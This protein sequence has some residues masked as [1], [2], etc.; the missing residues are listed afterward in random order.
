MHMNR[1]TFLAKA[2]QKKSRSRKSI[3]PADLKQIEVVNK[4]ANKVLPQVARTTAGLEPYTGTWGFDQASHLLR[5]TMFGI[6]KSDVQSMLSFSMNQV[7][8][9]LLA[10]IP[11]PL[12]PV[13]TNTLDIDVPIG[14]TWVNSPKTDSNGY[15]PNSSRI[16]SMKS[17][18]IGLMLNQGISLREKMTLFWHN[19][20]VSE[21]NIVSDARF[22]YKQNNLFRQYAF[23]NF[24]NLTKAVTIDGAMLR[25]L[26]GNTNTRTN[27][28]E[29]YARE[30]Q[31]LFTIGK[32]PEI[33]PGNY[34]NYTEA[35]VQAAAKI[36]T[37]WRDDGTAI[38]SYFTSSL[39]DTSNKQFSADYGNTI[40]AGQ[41]GT[42]GANEIDDFLTMI[43]A[44][45]ETAKFICRKLYRYFVYYV[46]D[47]TTEAN[48]IVP[49]ANILRSN[50]YEIKPVLDTLFKSAHF[51]DPVN[52]GCIIKN[53]IEDCVG[54]CRQFS[55]PFPD[56]TNVATQYANWNYIRTQAANM[57]MDIGDPPNVAGWPAYY[58]IP[59]YYE[60]WIN[61]DTLPR[62]NQLSDTLINSGHTT[63]G[64]KLI[65]DPIAFVNQVSN[66]ADPNIIIAEF[67]Q[68]L[69]PIAITANQTAFL[70]ETLIPGLPDY[71]WAIEWNSYLLDPTN[72]TKLT[73]VKTKLQA[74]IGFMMDMAE[75]QLQ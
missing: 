61:S 25:Y 53:P 55:I 9:Q 50:N 16:Q 73:A 66:P 28:N 63:S 29:N 58:Q 75:Y 52:I 8:A 41:I 13:N 49:L 1:R 30:L 47:T 67:V 40:I 37:G 18:W 68:I 35:D 27:P 2:S 54:L 39:H 4:F 6:K 42:A 31:E 23:G 11:L 22:S 62:R 21:T 56:S 32:G 45:Q 15:N 70:K 7:V 65:I 60:L 5:R 74:L 12:P 44:Q 24:K 10:D 20:F 46:I 19:H 38:T 59:Q 14:Q 36:L 43:F 17:W 48:V 64:F 33:A 57:Q 69:F 51:Y 3:L 71:E 26:N 72:Q 34:T